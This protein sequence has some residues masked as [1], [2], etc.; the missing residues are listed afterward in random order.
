MT[1]NIEQKIEQRVFILSED[2]DSIS[3][4]DIIRNIYE[5]NLLDE[6]R[7]QEYRKYVRIPIHLL[8][9][10]FGGSV[11]DGL[12]LIGAM[13]MSITPIV[14]ICM[15]SAQSMGLY[16]LAAGHYR[17]ATHLS[18]IMYHQLSGHISGQLEGLKN[19]VE[20]FQ[21][22][23]NNCDEMLTRRTKIKKS[24]LAYYKQTKT[25]WYMTPD[26]ALQYGIIDEI[27]GYPVTKK[28]SR[29]RNTE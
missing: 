23:E 11:Y 2:V 13:E 26:E 9:N 24:H 10:T 12:G 3:V 16:I 22:I 28:K 14:T 17:R 4:R 19:T 15:G 18:T 25:E 20:E 27:L 6:E 8:I 7:E 5:I 29:K 1:Q 21:R